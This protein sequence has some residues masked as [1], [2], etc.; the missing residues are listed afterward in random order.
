MATGSQP[1]KK[2]VAK[3]FQ[4]IS[5]IRCIF[6]KG[7]CYFGVDSKITEALDDQLQNQAIETCHL[8]LSYSLHNL[9]PKTLICLSSGALGKN[10]ALFSKHC[11]LL[12]NEM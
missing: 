1:Y 12:A 10:V 6:S 2:M 11:R 4:N 3:D 8:I 5:L 9:A 7:L